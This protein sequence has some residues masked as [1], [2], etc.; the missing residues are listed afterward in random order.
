[1]NKIKKILDDFK[2]IKELLKDEDKDADIGSKEP[3]QHTKNFLEHFEP[4]TKHPLEPTAGMPPSNKKGQR[5]TSTGFKMKLI[6]FNSSGQW[7][8][9]DPVNED[10]KKKIKNNKEN[11]AKSLQDLV[12]KLKQYREELSKNTDTSCFNDSDEHLLNKSNYGPKGYGLYNPND[13][14]NRKKNNTGDFFENT[15][16]NVN[17]KMYTTPGSSI[18]AAH[19]AKQQKEQ[20]KKAKASLRT[21]SEMSPEEKAEIASR[22]N[23]TFKTEDVPVIVAPKN[24]KNRKTY[25][26]EFKKSNI[27]SDIE[28][29]FYDNGDIDILAGSDVPDSVF[30]S[31]C[32]YLEKREWTPKAKHK[33]KSGGL[34]Q[35]GV[36]SYRRANPGSKLKTAVTEKKP[37][38][39]RAK[40]RKSFCARNKGQIDMHNIDCR[41]TPKKRACLARKKWRCKN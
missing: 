2:K 14:S 33:S 17:A 29:L 10:S 16:K 20:N 11:L 39:K 19:E 22:H 18:T 37:S 12:L 25:K 41:K 30:N 3:D 35:A 28:L 13:N 7:Y 40:R 8:L 34:T 24:S 36:E 15:G 9:S 32:E 21:F 26:K 5:V 23:A 31:A 38:G 6:K 27:D 1:M 4:K